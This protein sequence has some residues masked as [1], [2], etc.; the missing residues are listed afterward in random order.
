MYLIYI[1]KTHVNSRVSHTKNTFIIRRSAQMETF[2]VVPTHY[3]RLNGSFTR[4][5]VFPPIWSEIHPWMITEQ[6]SI[7]QL[8]AATINNPYVPDQSNASSTGEW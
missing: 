8:M 7:S 1:P 4:D 6:S 2:I 3:T 5:C